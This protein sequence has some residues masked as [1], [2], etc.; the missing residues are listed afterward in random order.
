MGYYPE[1]AGRARSISASRRPRRPR[2]GRLIHQQARLHLQ[3]ARIERREQD[4]QRPLI[5]AER[6]GRR[7]RTIRSPRENRRKI[8]GCRSA[9]RERR[10]QSRL[11]GHLLGT[12]R[13]GQ[14]E[15]TQIDD[16][17]PA[18]AMAGRSIV[19]DG[20]LVA[21]LLSRLQLLVLL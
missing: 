1:S 3:A 18:R 5:P 2:P 4:Q 11:Q 15:P 17:E 12:D 13:T 6:D 19:E 20:D 10:I 16:R 8:D 7:I 9:D 14:R 21:Q